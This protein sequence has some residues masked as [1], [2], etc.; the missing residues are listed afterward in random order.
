[1][2][3][4]RSTSRSSCLTSSQSFEAAPTERGSYK[5]IGARVSCQTFDAKQTKKSGGGR[6][7]LQSNTSIRA[8]WMASSSYDCD[9]EWIE[10]A[11]RS[12]HTEELKLE[13]SHGSKAGMSFVSVPAL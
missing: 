12:T 13:K 10:Y 9:M 7:V 8:P 3:T 5:F 6:D 1:V 2:I 11:G 4:N